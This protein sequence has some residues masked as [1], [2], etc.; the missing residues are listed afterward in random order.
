[1]TPEDRHDDLDD[2]ARRFLAAQR[3]VQPPAVDHLRDPVAAAAHLASLR[4]MIPP[5]DGPAREPVHRLLEAEVA[6]SVRER[7]RTRIYVPG[8]ERSYPLLIW[9]HGG[10]WVQGNLDTNDL[11]CR[12][13]ANQA[14]VAVMNVDYRLAPEHQF[15][16]GLSDCFA[17]VRWARDNGEEIGVDPARLMVGGSSAGGNLAAAF[18][19][20]ARDEDGPSVILQV[21]VCPVLDSSMSSSSY[22]RYGVGYNLNQR[23]MKWFYELYAPDEELWRDPLISPVNSPRHDGLPPAII[24]TAGCDPVRDEARAYSRLLSAAGVPVTELSYP[25]QIHG[26]SNKIDIFP[27]G[28]RCVADVSR[29]IRDFLTGSANNAGG[30]DGGASRA[31][32]HV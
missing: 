29:A 22:E 7:I 14:N 4:S 2:V 27:A 12:M 8:A 1:M 25:G 18:T 17:A 6:S 5:A 24:V 15:P 21:L 11:I 26:F 9:F 31:D 28:V 32:H 23:D 20:R 19:L 10:G 13:T 30:R 3:E 16:A